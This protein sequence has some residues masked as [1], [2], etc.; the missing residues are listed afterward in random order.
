MGEWTKIAWTDRTFNPWWHCVERGAECQNCYAR[1]FAKRTGFDV[2]GASKPAR[3]FGDKH[4]NEPLRWNRRAEITKDS[5]GYTN[6][7]HEP[8]RD[9][10]F[11]GSMCDVFEERADLIAPRLRLF[12]LICRTPSLCW[13]LLTKRP[14][15][16]RDLGEVWQGTSDWPDNVWLGATAGTQA[17]ANARIPHLLA[18]PAAVLFLSCEPLIGPIDLTKITLREFPVTSRAPIP[19][20][21]TCDGLRGYCGATEEEDTPAARGLQ[22]IIVGSESG[23][24]AR[25]MDLAWARSIVAQCR[26]AG[27]ACFV[28]QLPANNPRHVSTNPADFPPDLRVRQFPGVP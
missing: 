11:C 27:I 21:V 9:R 4:W 12:D 23:P 5:E 14:E 22:W 15:N 7:S 6:A 18:V 20:S 17:T 10:V 26:E 16:A 13:Q 19:A 24:H 1:T 8:A 3:F 2:W 25:P 28:K